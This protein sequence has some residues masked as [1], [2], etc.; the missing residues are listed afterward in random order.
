MGVDTLIMER[1]V[2]FN[3]EFTYGLLATMKEKSSIA[4]KSSSSAF[5]WYLTLN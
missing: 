5:R 2:G 4:L 1:Q 3:P